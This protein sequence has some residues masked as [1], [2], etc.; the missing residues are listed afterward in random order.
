M[1]APLQKYLRQTVTAMIELSVIIV[2]YN[3]REFL[4]NALVAIQKAI[5]FLTAN[6]SGIEGEI[7]VV[8]NASDDGSVE[9][10]R[11]N[12]PDVHLIVNKENLGFAKA[13]NIALRQSRGRYVL[14]INPDTVVQEDTFKVTID[15][16]ERNPDV[17]MAGCKILNPDGTLQLTCRRSFPTPWIA[18]SKMMGLSALFPHTR[19]F[20]RYNLTYLSPDESYEVDALSGSFM[21]FRREVYEQVGELDEDFFM[22]GED[23]D[24]CYRVQQAGWK[25]YYVASTQII[26]YK[27]ESTKRSDI[28]EIR[29][30][31][32]A[33]HLFVWKHFSKSF[34]VQLLLRIGIVFR[35][36]MAF[37][38]KALRVLIVAVVDWILINCAILL[39]EYLWLGQIFHFPQYAYPTVFIVPA[40]VFVLTLYF[41]GVY[42][43]RKSSVSR[44]FI[45]VI[46]GF[47]PVS[48]L[49]YFFKAYAFSR[50]VVLISSAINAMLLPGW[51]LMLR[52][53]G[54]GRFG[55]RKSLFGRKTLIVG[56][57]E[58]GQGVLRRLRA[59]VA[60]GY[61]VV[62]FIDVNRQR[63]GEEISGVR[64]LGSVDNVGKVI[65]ENRVSEVIF[66]TDALTYM[67]ILSVISRS[68]ERA[69]NF[70]LVP[71]SLEVIIGKTSIDQL[72]DIP[73]VEID[74][75][76]DRLSHRVVKRFFDLFFSL[77]L[78]ISVYP[79]VYLRYVMSGRSLS[80]FANGMLLLPQVLK[81]NL[82]IVGRSPGAIVTSSGGNGRSYLGK[83][84]LTGLVQIQARNDLSP[85]EIEKYNIYYA[86]NQ[87]LLLDVEILLKSLSLMF[88]GTSKLR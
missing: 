56:T 74:Y 38:A 53:L 1:E 32:Q 86:K 62:G 41:A 6:K 73:L 12:F 25:T 69:V 43:Y 85:E 28:D 8:D 45:S 61:E 23:L 16:F 20:G 42:T 13:N 44:T 35:T 3:V 58:S 66:S 79:F 15:F 18:F 70:R 46:I 72:D 22:Y 31:Y 64:I 63:L 52:L 76:L 36:G 80:A 10:V 87:S 83:V 82:S 29:T 34:L 75:N 59:R 68:R 11:A 2:N 51:R 30:F 14:L 40:C 78:L 21:M 47:F 81:G 54:R 65:R 9:L 37:V 24:W 48:S 49:T 71:S 50:A 7:F 4:E 17:G 84:G 88:K 39:G 60:D 26:H 77:F 67:D 33:M 55:G 27:G 19:M 57:G 5:S